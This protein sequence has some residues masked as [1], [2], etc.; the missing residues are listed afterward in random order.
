MF[1]KKHFLCV[2]FALGAQTLISSHA[3]AASMPSVELTLHDGK[4]TPSTL[5][6]P[7]NKRFKLVLHN[8]GKAPAEF[9]SKRLR[10]EKV[11]PAGSKTTVV[12][13]PLKPG[14]YEFVDEFH[15]PEAKGTI[16]A[17]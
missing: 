2:A 17:K 12:I 11:L 5:E 13:S 6:V 7:A 1:S 3:V 10:Q 16:I 15:E 8:T 4:L 9:E 14:Q